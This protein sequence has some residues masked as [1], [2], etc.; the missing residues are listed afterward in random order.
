MGWFGYGQVDTTVTHPSTS[1][2]CLSKC[3][4]LTRPGPNPAH[5]SLFVKAEDLGKHR[6][7]PSYRK[8]K[9][10]SQCGVNEIQKG[11]VIIDYQGDTVS[12]VAVTEKEKLL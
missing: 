5:D 12:D 3:D 11:L 7:N 4:S 9:R 10:S 8:N 6:K 2:S 1:D